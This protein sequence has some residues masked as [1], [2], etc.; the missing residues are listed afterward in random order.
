[1]LQRR[2]AGVRRSRSGVALTVSGSAALKRQFRDTW[3]S[4]R[5]LNVLYARRALR[6]AAGDVKGTLLDVGCG[7]RPY[8]R[9]FEGRVRAHF[10]M[11]W[12]TDGARARPDL[13]GDALRMPLAD[14]S[15]D[16]ILATEVMEHLADPN[17]FLS[18]AA[19]VLRPEGALVMSVPFLEPL[20]EEP[21]DY[22]RFT[23]YGL[24]RLLARHG[25]ALTRIWAK[26]GWWSVVIGSFVAKSLYD[27]AN[28]EQ[29]RAG[30]RD[31][32]WLLPVVVPLCAL[33]QLTAYVLDCFATSRKYALGYVVL[34]V[35]RC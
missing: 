16:T 27:C 25:F 34:A 4:P 26:G 21:R 5:Y 7:L 9:V 35:R 15:V 23:P 6:E 8:E 19:R 24:D 11:D 14:V 3:L 12:P 29:R 33:A 17:Q 28:P 20:H 13:F 18:E 30:G 22:Y 2:L 1:M 10:G 31:R 32:W